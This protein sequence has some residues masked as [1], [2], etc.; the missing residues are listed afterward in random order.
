[1]SVRARSRLAAIVLSLVPGWGHV[2]WGREPT[3]L[4]IFTLFAAA[5][6]S[7]VN[8]L[9]L[10][11]GGGRTLL[12]AFSLLLLGVTLA[13][14]WISILRWTSPSRIRS[15]EERRNQAFREGAAAF[16]R[17]DNDGAVAA[18]SRCVEVD[19]GDVEAL[20]RLGIVTARAGD[21]RGA[22]SWLR[23]AQKHDL[24]DK[25]AWEIERE[26]ERLKRG[27]AEVRVAAPASAPSG[28]AP[29]PLV[30]RESSSREEARESTT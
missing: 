3:G 2:Y 23:R 22:R 28:K 17:G 21:T 24:D 13:W 8:G 29:A 10:Y 19:P 27:G 12:V 6:F 25:W 15:I 5:A 18:F 11:L 26:L 14:S 16:V 20:F 30:A 4:L 9:F 7:L 1:M